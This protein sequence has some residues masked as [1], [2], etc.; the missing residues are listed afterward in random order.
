M[1][2]CGGEVGVEVRRVVGVERVGDVFGVIGVGVGE[3]DCGDVWG[4]Y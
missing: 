2:D 4:V 1:S 3:W